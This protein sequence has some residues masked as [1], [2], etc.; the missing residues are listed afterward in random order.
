MPESTIATVAGVDDTPAS[1]NIAVASSMTD[2]IEVKSRD[3]TG[4][5]L[6][7]LKDMNQSLVKIVGEVRTGAETIATAS[8]EIASGNLDLSC[9]NAFGIQ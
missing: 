7:A 9:P 5:L 3:E 8:D 4:R 1:G 6:Q 2:R